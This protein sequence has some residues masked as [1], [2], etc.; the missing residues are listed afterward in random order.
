MSGAG[1]RDRPGLEPDPIRD[2]TCFDCSVPLPRPLVVGQAVVTRRTY[3]VV[4]IR[5]QS[6]LEGT[7]YA[8]GRGLPVAGDHRERARTA[9]A[10]RR[11]G[12]ARA[13]SRP[14]RRGVL[15]LRRARAVPGRCER[16]RP[17]PLG[18]ARPPRRHS[19]RRP[20]RQAPCGGPRLRRRRLQAPGRRRT[21][22]SPG[23]DGRVPAARLPGGEGHDRRRRAGGRRSPARRGPRG[24]RS[25]LRP[26]RR[27]LP[28]VHR[29]STMRSAGC[30]AWRS[31]TSPT[32]RTRSRRAWRPS[33]P[34]CGGAP[35][36]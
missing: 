8:F 32:S 18:P 15:A 33:S 22:R 19:A 26:R 30:G 35:G 34:I 2:V 21:R 7:A 16:R 25:R 10:R 14:A 11:F 24:R 29:A 17:R 4:R 13:A 5:T 9:P 6:G 3:A 23:R 20:A 1:G 28:V 12:A 36:C 31:S 27:R